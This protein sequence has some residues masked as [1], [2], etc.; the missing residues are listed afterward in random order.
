MA[1]KSTVF[2]VVTPCIS[3]L[4]WLFGG[5]CRPH[6]EGRRL[7]QA[8]NLVCCLHYSSTLKTE[9]I[10]CFDTFGALR[11]T[12]RHN[13]QHHSRRCR[14]SWGDV[15]R[16]NK[17]HGC[18]SYQYSPKYLTKLRI[19]AKKCIGN[20]DTLYRSICVRSPHTIDLNLGSTTWCSSHGLRAF[21]STFWR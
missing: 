3:E 7:S 12:R 20:R 9:A 13:L 4:A 2:W 18:P 8:R 15:S 11:T 10:C 6:I 5:T 16:D 21:V 17:R 14:S 19:F 1:V